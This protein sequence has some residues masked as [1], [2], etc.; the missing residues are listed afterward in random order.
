MTENLRSVHRGRELLAVVL[1]LLLGSCSR[2]VSPDVPEGA[3]GNVSEDPG[4]GS[5]GQAAGDFGNAAPGSTPMSGTDGA[6]PPTSTLPDAECLADTQEAE[7]VPVDMYIMLDKSGS[8]LEPTGGDGTG[9]TKWD[10]VREAL[11]MFFSDP[12]SDG[13]G[14]GLQ[15]FPLQ[16]PGVP[17]ECATEDDCG[18]MGG[19]CLTS[20]C[21]P[22]PTDGPGFQPA[23]CLSDLDCPPLSQCLPLGLCEDDPMFGCFGPGPGRCE[24]LGACVALPGV[25]LFWASCEVGMYFEPAVP[26]DLLPANGTALTDSLAAEMPFGLTPTSAALAGAINRAVTHA[27]DN[28]ERRAIAVLAT[29]GL[30]TDCL[31]VEIADV[32]AI[33]AEGQTLVPSIQTYVIGVFASGDT[34]AQQNLDQLASAGGSDRAFIVDPGQDVAAQFLAALDE[35]RGGVLQ[36][37]YQL[38]EAPADVTLDFGRVNVTLTEPDMV[39]DLLYVETP[40]NCDQAPMAWYYD[41]APQDGT[42]NAIRVCDQT[43]DTLMAATEGRIDIRLGCETLRPD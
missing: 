37:E 34:I 23:A 1:C 28:S 31:P 9:P 18:M 38:P 40:D 6:G 17:E 2:E 41:V 4:A 32:A 42:P 27:R 43:C 5:D 10:A 12:G 19:P 25:C 26:I 33:A 30:P 3:E 36:C 16:T 35:I 7:E 15:Y 20:G 39:S 24:D 21:T 22:R 13:L 29:D 14:V 11:T 8:M